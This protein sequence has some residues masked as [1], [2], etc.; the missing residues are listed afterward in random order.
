MKQEVLAR[1]NRLLSFHYILSIL[2]EAARIENAA[3]NSSSVISC[4][5][6]A[7]GTYFPKPL[8][9]NDWTLTYFPYL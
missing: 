9:S 7:A 2:Y 6:V 3:C 8:P 4:V 1:N 5:F